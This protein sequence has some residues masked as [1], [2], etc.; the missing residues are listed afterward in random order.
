MNKTF[1]LKMTAADVL[2]IREAVDLG[3]L[4]ELSNAFYGKIDELASG[5]EFA[6]LID[7]CLEDVECLECIA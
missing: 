6:L 7:E 4:P 1:K 2:A 3:F 5:V